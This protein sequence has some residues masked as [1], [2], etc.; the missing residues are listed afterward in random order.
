MKKCQLVREKNPLV[1]VQ[2]VVV[3]V[4]EVVAVEEQVVVEIVGKEEKMNQ[5]VNLL[6]SKKVRLVY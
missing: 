5:R 2:G 1:E 6:V 4:R 3:E